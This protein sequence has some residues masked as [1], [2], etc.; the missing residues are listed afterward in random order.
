MRVPEIIGRIESGIPI[1]AVGDFWKRILALEI[2][3]SLEIKQEMSSEQLQLVRHIY[4]S[5]CRFA[6]LLDC[7]IRPF[8]V[9]LP[10]FLTAHLIRV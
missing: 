2:D 1:I 4:P 7:G 3:L 6:S 8:R 9:R 5:A 10:C